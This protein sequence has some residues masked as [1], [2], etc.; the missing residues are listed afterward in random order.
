[1]S[2]PKA[3]IAIAV[4][5]AL[6]LA[7]LLAGAGYYFL[8]SNM[9]TSPKTTL[10]EPQSSLF[11]P[12]QVPPASS[13]SAYSASPQ[14]ISMPVPAPAPL[15]FS[16]KVDFPASKGFNSSITEDVASGPLFVLQ[17]GSNGTVPF[18]VTS[19][20]DESYNVSL[21]VF[22]GSTEAK[23]YGVQFS[24]SPANFPQP[25]RTGVLGSHDLRDDECAYGTVLSY[26]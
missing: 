5:S 15:A 10:P 18:S 26:N 13:Q 20:A 14:P 21:D 2:P 11:A 8:V 22:L 19:T 16:I 17:P 7:I 25:R 24:I 1:M 3:K 6:V 23:S 4:A 9:N 12:T